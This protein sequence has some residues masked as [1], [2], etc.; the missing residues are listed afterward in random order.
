MSTQKGVWLLNNNLDPH[1]V[2]PECF[3]AITPNGQG[4]F[5]CENCKGTYDYDDLFD[6]V[7]YR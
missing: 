4:G 6:T 7:S 1:F 3:C 2:C 5:V